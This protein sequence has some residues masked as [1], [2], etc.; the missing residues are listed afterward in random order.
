MPVRDGQQF[1]SLATELVIAVL[2]QLGLRDLLRC[3]QVCPDIPWLEVTTNTN[4]GM[5][6]TQN[7]H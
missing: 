7:S 3:K 2:L 6:T 5:P 4:V 1:V